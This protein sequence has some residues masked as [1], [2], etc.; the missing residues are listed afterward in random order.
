MANKDSSDLRLRDC[1]VCGHTVP[2]EANFCPKCGAPQTK[3]DPGIVRSNGGSLAPS[4]REHADTH[5]S[6]A[7]RRYAEAESGD[8]DRAKVVE[9]AFPAEGIVKC[10][11]CAEEIQA[12]ARKCRHCGEWLGSEDTEKSSAR[13]PKQFW[14]AIAFVCALLIGLT[15]RSF[16][17]A[18]F[19]FVLA[20]FIIN[21]RDYT[22]RR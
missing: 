9:I 7:R 10:P 16:P 3:R 6:V 1:I 22:S 19:I 15:I 2:D 8:S 13:L 11:Y 14:I 18:I 5:D 4:S 12:S 20:I 21:L 17:V